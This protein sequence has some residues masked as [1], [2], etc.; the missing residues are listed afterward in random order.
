MYK[1]HLIP[2]EIEEVRPSA[3]EIPE[4]VQMVHGPQFWDKTGNK[5]DGVVV[6]V[7]DTSANR[8]TQTCRSADS[9]HMKKATHF[10]VTPVVP[11]RKASCFCCPQ[12]SK[13][14]L[15]LL[16]ISFAYLSICPSMQVR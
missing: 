3:D 7:P 10:R 9:R 12:R 13:K 2:Y 15:K 1:V 5:G 8:T 14:L 16:S 4:G 11:T 6:A